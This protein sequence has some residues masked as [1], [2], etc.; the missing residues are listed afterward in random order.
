MGLTV[1]SKKGKTTCQPLSLSLPVVLNVFRCLGDRLQIL[2][3]LRKL[4]QIEAEPNKVRALS[5]CYTN[6]VREGIT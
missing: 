2:H 5:Q 3:S 6:K 1:L 4:W